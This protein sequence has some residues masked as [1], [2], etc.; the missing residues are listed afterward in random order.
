MDKINLI[1]NRYGRLTVL[2]ESGKDKYGKIMW[3]CQ[4]DCG[5]VVDVL[6]NSLRQGVTKSCGCLH[7][8]IVSKNMSGVHKQNIYNMDN[9]FGICFTN[10]M[11]ASFIFDKEDYEKLKRY[12]W[13]RTDRGY[14]ITESQGKHMVLHR[15]LM[16]A[17]RDMVVDH[18]N[19]NISDNRKCNLRICTQQHNTW[20][21]NVRIDNKLGITGVYQKKNGK[22]VAQ[23]QCKDFHR[24]K[25]FSTLNAAIQQRNLWEEEW[26]KEYRNGFISSQ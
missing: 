17:P 14:F 13:F 19:H 15:Y 24:Y 5:N 9:D 4:C 7:N 12:Y 1:G 23:M 10:D 26:F 2:C 11:M 25:E 16:N 3:K 20:N 18:I 6:G 22:Y 8:E 21:R